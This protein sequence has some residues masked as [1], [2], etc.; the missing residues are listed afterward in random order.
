MTESL[1]I[2]KL[3]LR[4]FQLSSSKHAKLCETVVIRECHLKMSTSPETFNELCC[5]NKVIDKALNCTK[6]DFIPIRNIMAHVSDDQPWNITFSD[7]DFHC[8]QGLIGYHMLLQN[9]NGNLECCNGNFH[10]DVNRSMRLN[11][12]TMECFD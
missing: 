1:F 4:E 9:I 5:E 3:Q 8:H 11:K 7:F 12:E 10:E 6:K 2:S